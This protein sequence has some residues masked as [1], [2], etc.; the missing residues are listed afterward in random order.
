MSAS[1]ERHKA[2][3]GKLARGSLLSRIA[4]H[5]RKPLRLTAVPRDHVEGDRARGDALLAGQFVLGHRSIAL[6]DLDFASLEP[7]DALNG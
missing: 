5:G 2:I 6:A 1:A 7:G 3:V 4:G